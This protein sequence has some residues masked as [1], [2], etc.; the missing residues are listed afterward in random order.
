LGVYNRIMFKHLATTILPPAL[1][2][3]L[4]LLLKSRHFQFYEHGLATTHSS[5]FMADSRFKKA[6]TAGKKTGSWGGVEVHWVA[7]VA[8]WAATIGIKLDGD[9]VECGVNRGGMARTILEFVDLPSSGKKFYLLDTFEG[10][11]R[12]HISSEESRN[13]IEPGGYDPCYE[14]VVRT[15]APFANCVILVKGAVP[16]TLP[17]AVP[18]KL[19]YLSIDMNCVGPEIAAA[20]FYW[21]R[22]V[23]GAVML[24]DDY[25]WTRHS[26]QKRAFDRFARE[27]DVTILSF[28]T[29]QGLIIKP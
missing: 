23:H 9:F 1:K 14:E 21:P 2:G 5:E 26:A 16:D 28:P 18:D 20:E 27:R 8:C 4:S 22:M 24:L 13:G 29:G 17:Q 15:F 10:L 19:A 3:P 11:L 25:G 6:Y 7:H 12:E